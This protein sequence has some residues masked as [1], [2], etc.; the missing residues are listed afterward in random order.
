MRAVCLSFR[1]PYALYVMLCSPLV[2][3]SGLYPECATKVFRPVFSVLGLVQLCLALAVPWGQHMY[4]WSG[5]VWSARL[6]SGLPDPVGRVLHLHTNCDVGAHY[7]LCCVRVD[8]TPT[9][10]WFCLKTLPAT[11]PSC[12]ADW[13]IQDTNWGATCHWSP[14]DAGRSCHRPVI[15]RS[16]S[17]GPGLALFETVCATAVATQLVPQLLFW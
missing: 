8:V 12:S 16:P 3:G 9:A 14:V 4:F 5:L 15:A 11:T 1:R 2:E 6:W 7:L 13:H 17:N 10:Q